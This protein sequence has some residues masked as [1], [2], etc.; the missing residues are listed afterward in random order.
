MPNSSHTEEIDEPHGIHPRNQ[1]K[2]E[3]STFEQA[4]K[5]QAE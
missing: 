5:E 2:S 1:E 4:P 3:K